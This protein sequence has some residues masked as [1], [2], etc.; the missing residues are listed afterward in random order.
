[1]KFYRY[2]QNNSGGRLLVS[3]QDGITSNVWVEARNARIANA[4]FDIIAEDYRSGCPCCG[5]RWDAAS[6]DDGEDEPQTEDWYSWEKGKYCVPAATVVHYL[7]GRIEWLPVVELL[8]EA[9]P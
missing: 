1:M 7:D 8:P 3:E 5:T 2:H 4:L 9:R 6:E